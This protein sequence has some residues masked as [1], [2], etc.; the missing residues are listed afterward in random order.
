V[1]GV[2]YGVISAV[3]LLTGALMTLLAGRVAAWVS[4]RRGETLDSSVVV[5][6]RLYGVLFFVAGLL[7]VWLAARQ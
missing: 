4:R 3:L 2:A 1:S 5:Y 6:F 7:F